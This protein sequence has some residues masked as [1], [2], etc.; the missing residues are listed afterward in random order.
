MATEQNLSEKELLRQETY[1]RS[2]SGL[3]LKAF[4]WGEGSTPLLFLGSLEGQK[5]SADFLMYFAKELFC[6]VVR[7]PLSSDE[8]PEKSFQKLLPFLASV[9]TL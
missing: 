5:A 6:A 9:L 8:S 3:P 7:I 4:L 2:F 1:G